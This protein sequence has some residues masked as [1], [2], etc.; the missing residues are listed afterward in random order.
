MEHTCCMD[1]APGEEAL[2]M[3][4]LAGTDG[5][6]MHAERHGVKIYELDVGSGRFGRHP[7]LHYEIAA[8]IRVQQCWPLLTMIYP[9]T[10]HEAVRPCYHEGKQKLCNCVRERLRHACLHAE[11]A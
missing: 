3:P 6:R 11:T 5:W 8:A 4:V 1:G 10:S 2:I 9:H 7:F